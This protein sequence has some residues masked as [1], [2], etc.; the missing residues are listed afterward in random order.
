MIMRPFLFLLILI[1]FTSC[2]KTT[3]AEYITPTVDP[4]SGLNLPETPFNYANIPL[5]THYTQNAFSAQAQFQRAAVDFDNT[6]ANNL[7]TDAGATLGRVLFYDEKLSA[8]GA[9][10]C[11]SCHQQAFGFSDPERLSEGFEGGRTRR[12]SMGLVNARFYFSGKFFW[13]ERAASLEEQV[14][15]PIQDEVEMGLSLP[16]LEQIVQSQA[17]YPPLFEAAFGDETITSE[18]IGLALAQFVRSLVSTTAK[19]DQ[20]R[21]EVSNPMVDF[22]AFTEQENRGK[23][24]FFRPIA[25]TKGININCAGCHAS[26][27]FVSPIPNGPMASTASANN[28]LDAVSTD[29]QGVFEATRNPNDIGKFKSPSLRNIGIRPPY[30]HDGRFASLEE[31]VEHYN[32]GIQNHPTLAPP[33][34]DEDGLPIRLNL[35]EEDKAA[36]VAFLHTLTDFDMMNDEKYS[37]P[38]D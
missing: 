15:Q 31:V 35:S 37:N 24:L 32:S 11:A 36:L 14:L 27:A 23:A 26:E 2:S 30:M 16:A 18:R 33:L 17:Y 20:A 1:V 34:R 21:A 13:D 4:F 28:G 29:D 19:Y 9:V 6:P 3:E 22:P 5:P 25:S 10:S 7:I 8:N 38:F 12:H